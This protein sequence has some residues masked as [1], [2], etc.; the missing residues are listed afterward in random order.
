[1]TQVIESKATSG[2]AGKLAEYR[3][4]RDPRRTCEPMPVVGSGPADGSSFVVQEH[5]A[6]AL[7]WDFRLERDGVLVSWAVPKGLPPDPSVNHLAVQTEDH[8]LAYA[9]YEGTIAQ[10]EY[11]GGR[12]T[13]WDHGTYQLEKWTER[14]VKIVLT[15]ERVQGRY[16]LIHTNGKNWIMHRMDG[17]L[18]DDWEPLPARLDPMLAG[19]GALPSAADDDRWAYEMKWDG[20]RAVVRVDGGRVT[21]RSRNDIDMTVAYPELRGLGAQVGTTQLMLDGEIVSFDEH[22]RPSFGRLQKR[23]HVGNAAV[24]RKLVGSDPAV[25]L[26]FDLLHVEGRSTLSLPYAERRRLLEGLKLNGPS[27]QTPPAFIGSGA[28]AVRVSKDQQLEGVVAKRLTSVYTPG[29]RSP[30][31]IKIKNIRTQEVIVGGWRPGTGRRS[32]SLGSLLVGLPTETGLTYVGRVGTG[33][34]DAILADLT[35]RLKRMARATSPFVDVPRVDARDAH[36]VTPRLVGEVAFS[37]WTS[38]SRL[39]HPTWRG[40]RDDKMPTDV[41]RES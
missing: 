32:E 34:S 30:D 28:D 3:R 14:E 7:H 1:M 22:G 37:E 15:G 33:F 6:T 11:G 36:W 16:V 19:A 9:T 4:K 20:V 25:L 5:H 39:R 18:R 40:L 10:G 13:I 17:P 31:W 2:P 26:I 27:W 35:A 38:D 12:V 23:M 21:A 24:A 8:P 29:R 41:V